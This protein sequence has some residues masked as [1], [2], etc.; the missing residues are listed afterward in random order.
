[1]LATELREPAL[2]PGL[3][4]ATRD[5]LG[6]RDPDG[7]S[8]VDLRAA[9][10]LIGVLGSRLGGVVAHGPYCPEETRKTRTGAFEAAASER[11]DTT[12][13]D[14]GRAVETSWPGPTVAAS[15]RLA[16]GSDGST[17]R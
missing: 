9:A 7:S 12:Q 16:D 13:N 5:G 1:V 15:D 10:A 14:D 2:V 6:R 17:G 8:L 3:V 11:A 4:L